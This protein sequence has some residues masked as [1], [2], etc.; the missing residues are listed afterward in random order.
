MTYKYKEIMGW[1]FPESDG[2]FSVFCIKNN[3]TPD[4]YQKKPREKSLKYV[5][6]FGIA[7]D[8]GAHIGMWSK[9]LIE[10]FDHVIAFEPN[11]EY[12]EYYKYNL[13]DYSNYTIH[14]VG[15]GAENKDAFLKDVSIDNNSGALQV[16]ETTGIPIKILRLDFFELTNI[17]YIK[18]DVEGY[19]Q[20]VLLGAEQTLKRCRPVVILEANRNSKTFDKK[21]SSKD[22]LNK[23][24]ATLKE[25]CGKE[26][27]YTWY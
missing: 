1:R 5:K 17:D 20:N 22:I 6:N 14:N 11:P 9:D 21:R 13:S 27:I 23:F 10:K 2:P 4:H 16:S 12:V 18:I 25:V 19:E 26:Q 24:G 15:L 3:K 7:I 8:I